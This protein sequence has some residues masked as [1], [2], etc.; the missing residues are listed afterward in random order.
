M[1]ESSSSSAGQISSS[2]S[3]APAAGGQCGVEAPDSLPAEIASLPSVKCV[4]VDQFG[5]LPDAQKVAV[6]RNPEQGFDANIAFTP[7]ASY[8]LVNTQ[9]NQTVFTGAPT[10]WNSGAVHSVSGDSAWWFDFSSVT[11]TGEYVVVDEQNRVRSPAFRIDA[12]V[13]REVLVQAVRTF[14]YQRAGFAKATPYA[15]PGWADG[16]SHLG[17]GQDTEARL[18]NDAGNASTERDLSGGWYD[19][20]DYNKYTNWHADYLLTLLHMYQENPSVWTDDFNLPESGNGIPDLIDEIKWGMA[21]LIKMQENNGSVLS[22]MGLHHASPPSAATGASTYGPATTAAT[23]SSAAAFALGSKILGEFETLEVYASD[24]INRAEQAWSWAAANPAEIFYNSNNVAAGE[25]EVDDNGR[26]IKKRTA[27]IYLFAATNNANYRTFVDA[28]TPT[29]NWVGPWNQPELRP[30]LYYASLDNAT[31]AKAEAIRT[32]Y[33]NAMNNNWND[34]GSDPYRAFLGANDFTWGSNRTMAYQ[35]IKFYNQT[36][37]SLGTQ[38]TAEVD[39]AA[40]GYLNYLHGVNPLG[41]VY[42]SNMGGHGAED[43]VDSFYH[44]WF[45][46]GSPNWDSVTE[47]S[48]GPAPGFLVGGPNPS[49]SWDGCCPDSCGGSANNAMCGMAPLSPPAGQPPAKSYLDFNDSWP[50]NSWSVTENHNAYQVAYIYLLSK[51]VQ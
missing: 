10:A 22:V 13:Y 42:L 14:F 46:N 23:L 25:Q 39:S 41:K 24:L 7:G 33:T 43:S 47:S 28:N 27:A 48:F 18:W 20:G 37:Y 12:N 29:I 44:S 30:Q 17:A 31:S 4:V 1:S 3:S 6:L 36:L 11:A 19:A 51:Y 2:S 16:A 49:Y 8:S 9:T 32:Q 38:S 34:L 21:W 26:A 45:S 5:Y 35:G 15:G 40:L 50:L